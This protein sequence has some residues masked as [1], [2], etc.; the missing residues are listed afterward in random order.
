M[1]LWRWWARPSSA[2]ARGR[3]YD[4]AAAAAEFR[5]ELAACSD[6][7]ATINMASFQALLA[8]LETDTMAAE[9]AL[10]RIDDALALAYQGD[11]RS[12]IASAAR[13]C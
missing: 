1:T 6:Q 5:R 7:G 10:K 2:W 4:P 11:N 9:T 13:S 8:Q 3:L 12:S